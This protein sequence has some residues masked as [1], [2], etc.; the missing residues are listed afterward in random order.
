M[1]EIGMD[2]EFTKC[3]WGSISEFQTNGETEDKILQKPRC[4]IGEGNAPIFLAVAGGIKN[5][6]VQYRP[7]LGALTAPVA[8]DNKD[9]V[10]RPK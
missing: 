8:S 4:S 6:S 10:I 1:I 7:S 5:W 3:E 2:L 9:Y